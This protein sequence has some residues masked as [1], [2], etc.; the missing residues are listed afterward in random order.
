MTHDVTFSASTLRAH[1]RVCP[2]TGKPV[3][4]CHPSSL[5]DWAHAGDDTGCNLKLDP[6][7][8]KSS[9]FSVP[10]FL[11]P[12]FA[13]LASKGFLASRFFAGFLQ[14][15][16]QLPNSRSHSPRPAGRRR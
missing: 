2:I 14:Y 6:D 10:M 1:A 16:D 3:T 9:A 15:S 13:Q 12:S 7:A 5:V 8:L 11:K 4:M